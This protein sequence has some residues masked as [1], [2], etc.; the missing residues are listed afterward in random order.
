MGRGDVAP[1]FPDPQLRRTVTEEQPALPLSYYEQRIPVPAG[2]DDHP[3][4]YLLFGPPYEDVAA[5]A[6]DRG[7]RVAHLPGAHLHQ[8]VDPAGTARLVV[9]LAAARR[10]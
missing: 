3:C 2:W 4:S 5:E 7:W 6:R 9:G 8:I 10:P 1:M